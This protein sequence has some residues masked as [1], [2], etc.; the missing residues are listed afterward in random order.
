MIEHIIYLNNKSLL[1]K[2]LTYSFYTFHRFKKLLKVTRKKLSEYENEDLT[3]HG[4]LR[5]SH[6][7]TDIQ[8]NMLKHKVIFN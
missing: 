3:F 7:E 2:N 1:L 4:D 6:T 5:T 8:I